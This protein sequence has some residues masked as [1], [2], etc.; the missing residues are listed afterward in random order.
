MSGYTKFSDRFRKIELSKLLAAKYTLISCGD[1][2]KPDNTLAASAAL[3]GVPGRVGVFPEPSVIA[4]AEFSG[5]AELPQPQ[6]EP[7]Y[8]Q[9]CPTRRGLIERRG[10]VFLH[11]CAVCGRWGAFG[12]G[13]PSLPVKPAEK[14]YCGEHRPD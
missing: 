8:D 5:A 1:A 6:D 14:W 7:P 11:F 4:P 12:Y 2:Q 10:G 13:P 3:A 9:P